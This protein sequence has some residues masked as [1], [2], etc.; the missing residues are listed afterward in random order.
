MKD[1]IKHE[2]CTEPYNG[3]VTIIPNW[4]NKDAVRPLPQQGH[5]SYDRWTLKTGSS[6][7]TWVISAVSMR[8]KPSWMPLATWMTGS[9]LFLFYGEGKQSDLVRQAAK[10]SSHRSVR[11]LP[12]Q[13]R[14]QLG[15]TLTGCDVSLV[16]LRVGLSGLAVPSKLYG[17]LAS[18]KPI[19]AIAPQDCEKRLWSCWRT[20][21]ARRSPRGMR[22][23]SPRF[24]II[25]EMTVKLAA[26]LE[27][28]RAAYLKNTMT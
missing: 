3:F 28:G 8:S 19:V 6:C 9:F 27:A 24:S 17:A 26:A 12:F 14:E 16:T 23:N 20:I 10:E 15:L 4:A 18:G 11:L 25:C 7:F 22:N 5:R 2:L 1:K 13:P 21:V